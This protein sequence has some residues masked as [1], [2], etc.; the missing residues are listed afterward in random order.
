MAKIDRVKN[1]LDLEDM[2]AR[3]LVLE[4]SKRIPKLEEDEYTARIGLVTAEQVTVG[5]FG[6]WVKVTIP[7][8]INI[9]DSLES[10]TVNFVANK[11]IAPSSRMYPI[12]KGILGKSPENGFTLSE[13]N[14][15]KV[16][17]MI[18]HRTDADGN[19]WENIAS[20]RKIKKKVISN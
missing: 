20:V 1:D 7:F 8:K 2:D 14:G 16:K 6:P 10:L 19:V 12:I 4:D 17:V 13:I 18:E 3:L 15:K 9:P 11:S 5:Q